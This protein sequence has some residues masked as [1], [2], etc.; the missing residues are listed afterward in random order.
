M[1]PNTS[2]NLRGVGCPER[3][4]R[5]IL[6][7]EIGRRYDEK[8]DALNAQHGKG[9]IGAADLQV[10]VA[11]MWD[12]Q[13]DL[14]GRLFSTRSSF[15][16][17]GLV[18]HLPGSA[19]PQDVARERHQRAIQGISGETAPIAFLEPDPS[20]GLNEAQMEAWNQVYER[21]A[22][23]VGGPGQNPN[24]PAYRE[25]WQEAQVKADDQLKALFGAANVIQWEMRLRSQMPPRPG[26]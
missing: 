1:T 21:F 4:I 18:T 5:D 23:A 13:N 25:R 12:E 17:D 16:A 7:A 22:A 14:I 19:S 24:D 10:A 9:E 2:S 15:G 3:T 26:E 11:K 20:L 6:G 8:R